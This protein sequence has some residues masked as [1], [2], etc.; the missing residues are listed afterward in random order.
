[1]KAGIGYRVVSS[2]LIILIICSA[3]TFANKDGYSMDDIL[4]TID[5]I[6]H[7]AVFHGRDFTAELK[8]NEDEKNVPNLICA[9]YNSNGK[10]INAEIA[11]NNVLESKLTLSMPV[12]YETAYM[13]LFLLD[14]SL[15]PISGPARKLI[16]SR[17]V[18]LN[19]NF[20]NAE[21]K[22]ISITAKSGDTIA[23]NDGYAKVSQ[24]GA[25]ASS[26]FMQYSFDKSTDT[27]SELVLEAEI[28]KDRNDA[29]FLAEATM[30][31]LRYK[32]ADN[33]EKTKWLG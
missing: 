13:K 25:A 20:E 17:Y 14:D 19:E 24:S 6:K 28:K 22:R 23:I 33:N 2:F 11:K 9:Q 4:C 21:V 29:D 16:E 18:Y 3:I 8:L 26:S 15:S 30:F 32:D 27:S 12:D 7:D 5:G 10:L 31:M 1:M